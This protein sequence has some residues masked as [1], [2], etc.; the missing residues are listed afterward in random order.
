MFN[1]F[2]DA[3]TKHY[4][5]FN[6]RTRRAAFWYFYLVYIILEIVLGVV[7]GFTHMGQILTSILALGLLL[8]TI[9]IAVRRYHDTDHSGWW[10]LCPLMNIVF[11]FFAGTPGPNTYGPDP[12]AA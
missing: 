10:I 11:L 1:Y 12:K 7:E 9:G 5:D 2:I 4:V 3:V 8:P 6:G